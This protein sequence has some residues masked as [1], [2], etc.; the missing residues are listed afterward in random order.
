VFL[1]ISQGLTDRAEFTG[2]P[3]LVIGLI[4]LFTD[5]RKVVGIPSFHN[6]IGE[7]DIQV[8]IQNADPVPDAFQ[9][10]PVKIAP[11]GSRLHAVEISLPPPTGGKSPAGHPAGV[12]AFRII[13]VIG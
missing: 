3:A 5:E 7:N 11:P 2:F 1:P 10:A 12:L 9:N 6:R 4:T 8:F 13:W